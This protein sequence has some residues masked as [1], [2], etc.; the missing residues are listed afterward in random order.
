[1]AQ[2][3]LRFSHEINTSAQIGD[4][5]YFTPTKDVAGAYPLLIPGIQYLSVYETEPVVSNL[6]IFWETTTT[7]LIQDLNDFI[8]NETSGGSTLFPVAATSFTEEI[9]FVR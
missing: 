7:G 5:L 8:L 4:V 9:S 6:D 2:I 1:M 3:T